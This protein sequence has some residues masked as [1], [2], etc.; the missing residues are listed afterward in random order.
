MGVGC[1]AA[2]S[3]LIEHVNRRSPQKSLLVFVLIMKG[4]DGLTDFLPIS[5]VASEALWRKMMH[6]WRAS[7]AIKS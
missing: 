4:P 7:D 3:L 6:Y 1:S 2:H 5:I